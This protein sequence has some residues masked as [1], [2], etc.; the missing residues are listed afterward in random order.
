MVIH[1]LLIRKQIKNK[2]K[3]LVE[4]ALMVLKMLLQQKDIRSIAIY[5]WLFT[6][7]MT[8]HWMTAISII[9]A[10]SRIQWKE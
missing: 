4:L 9:D 8:V 1:Q 2:A 5:V 6:G 7:L 10:W 3:P